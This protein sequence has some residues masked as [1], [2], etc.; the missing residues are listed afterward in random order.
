MSGAEVA[1][2]YARGEIERIAEY[3]RQDVR[4][5]AELYRKV[6]DGVLRFRSD[7]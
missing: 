1:P 4:A 7:W 3:N 2:A 6:R 5:T